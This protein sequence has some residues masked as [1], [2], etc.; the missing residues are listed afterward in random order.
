MER[1]NYRDI[2]I[3]LTFGESLFLV[4]MWIDWNT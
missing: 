1:E 3:D 2:Q 4:K